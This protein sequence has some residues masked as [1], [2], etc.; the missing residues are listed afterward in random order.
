M[1]RTFFTFAALVSSML[2]PAATIQAQSL[3]AVYKIPF[4]FT[5]QGVTLP[6][7]QYSIQH[8]TAKQFEFL[9]SKAGSGI[10]LPAGP[11]LSGKGGRLVFHKYGDRYFLAQVW[12]LDGTGRNLPVSKEERQ[13]SRNPE[14]AKATFEQITLLA[15]R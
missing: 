11:Q 3:Q 1:K 13:L 12:E 9:R 2:L 15:Q 4:N 5:A 6:S 7:G 8:D 10:F 14:M